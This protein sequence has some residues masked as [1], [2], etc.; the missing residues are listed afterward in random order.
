VTKGRLVTGR[1]GEDLAA[2]RLEAEG[3]RLLVRN[4]RGSA[5]EIDIVALDGACLVFVEVR[6]RRGPA[7]GSP[8]ESLGARK[9]ARMARLAEEYV[10]D[11][12]WPG[13]WRV[14][15]MAIAL[16]RRPE[17]VAVEHY[18]DAVLW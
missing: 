18:R 3:W 7:F 4:W 13:P 12:G 1:W 10:V 5:G 15:V 2:A 17:Q 8:A 11:S 14:D 9:R 16:G 6:T